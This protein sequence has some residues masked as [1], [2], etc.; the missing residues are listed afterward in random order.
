MLEEYYKLDKYCRKDFNEEYNRLVFKLDTQTL[1]LAK[2]L[3]DYEFKIDFINGEL[4]KMNDSMY[5]FSTMQEQLSIFPFNIILSF[6]ETIKR[7]KAYII[8]VDAQG[9]TFIEFKTKYDLNILNNTDTTISP[10]LLELLSK[11]SVNIYGFGTLLNKYLY[12]ITNLPMYEPLITIVDSITTPNIE[13]VNFQYNFGS[14]T[15]NLY[16]FP[17]I[18]HNFNYMLTNTDNKIALFNNEAY[19][20]VYSMTINLLNGLQT[21]INGKNNNN[22]YKYNLTVNANNMNLYNALLENGIIKTDITFNGAFSN[23]IDTSYLINNLQNSNININSKGLFTNSTFDKVI[24]D[25]YNSSLNINSLNNVNALNVLNNISNT[26]IYINN[27]VFTGNNT[28]NT[29]ENINDSTITFENVKL[30][31]YL[32]AFSNCNN[33][34]ISG[35]SNIS[36]NQIN[37]QSVSLFNNYIKNNNYL[38]NSSVIDMY[39]SINTSNEQWFNTYINVR[40][41][42]FNNNS[43]ELLTNKY[44]C[45]LNINSSSTI[46]INNTDADMININNCTDLTIQN[47]NINDLNIR[48][49]PVVNVNINDS[50]IINNYTENVNATDFEQPITIQGTAQ[51]NFNSQNQNLER[52]PLV[53][54]NNYILNTCVNPIYLSISNS[55]NVV[56]NNNVNEKL[57]ETIFENNNFIINIGKNFA[58]NPILISNISPYIYSISDYA[59]NTSLL[60]IANF[61]NTK[62]IDNNAFINTSGIVYL[63]L[64]SCINNPLNL[65]QFDNSSETLEYLNINNVQNISG[66]LSGFENLRFLIMNNIESIGDNMFENVENLPIIEAN[67]AKY[68]G[69]KA[70]YNSGIESVNDFKEIITVSSFAFGN[71]NNITEIKNPFSPNI[72]YGNNVFDNCDNLE[73]VELNN[74]NDKNNTL[75]SNCNNIKDFIYSGNISNINDIDMMLSSSNSLISY[76]NNINTIYLYDFTNNFKNIKNIILPECIDIYT[77][78]VYEN[79]Y[80]TSYNYAKNFR[81]SLNGSMIIST[82]IINAIAVDEIYHVYSESLNYKFG[83]GDSANLLL[84]FNQ[85]TEYIENLQN[86]KTNEMRIINCHNEINSSYIMNTFTVSMANLLYSYIYKT[87]NSISVSFIYD[88]SYDILDSE[89]NLPNNTIIPFAFNTRYYTVSLIVNNNKDEI[90]Y[91]ISNNAHLFNIST[92]DYFECLYRDNE[93]KTRT[94]NII[95]QGIPYAPL[96]MQLKLNYLGV[97]E[98]LVS[99]EPLNGSL[100]SQ[101]SYVSGKELLTPSY[102]L[103]INDLNNLQNV[104]IQ[105]INYTYDNMF[106]NDSNLSTINFKYPLLN[107]SNNAFYGTKLTSNT[108]KSI[109]ENTNSNIIGN[110]AFSN[111]TS[112][113]NNLEFNKPIIESSELFANNNILNISLNTDNISDKMFYNCSNLYSGIITSKIIGE[114]AFYNCCFET[115]ST[116]NNVSGLYIPNIISISNNAFVNNINLKNIYLLNPM[117]QPSKPFINCNPVNISINCNASTGISYFQDINS[118]KAFTSISNLSINDINN[119]LLNSSNI[120]DYLEI[121]SINL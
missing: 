15:I 105:N 100:I 120:I 115:L 43:V 108:I 66:D 111:M 79:I 110:N 40:N 59:L 41:V 76:T 14:N 8:P 118:I 28:T 91:T 112:V 104:N 117:T 90:T 34:N 70:F 45:E 21:L 46:I 109:I 116:K 32:Y 83:S 35:F 88:D 7:I 98:T 107:I 48:S 74:L 12:Q 38:Y 65:D 44:D 54:S 19:P 2:Y 64:S 99:D 61:E 106:K 10:D 68:I 11:S 96:N 72:E 69:Y 52:L 81:Y 49:D 77:P 94:F 58:E 85:Y 63:N 56:L 60:T 71:C 3:K 16:S 33:I 84:N 37:F 29:F 50:T 42:N 87:T 26:K 55:E 20:Q 18:L 36:S 119:I 101:T 97:N 86:L 1:A 9:I 78:E 89:Q 62:Y 4:T 93:T 67:N 102:Y 121:N 5:K 92:T 57:I 103:R 39:N 53:N 47:T 95:F 24:N 113:I 75:F 73:Y 51:I 27:T 80:I 17:I 82:K 22:N 13:R 23:T 25:I 6:D 30:I 31:S 114:N